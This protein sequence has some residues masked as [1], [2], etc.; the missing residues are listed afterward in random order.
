M[1]NINLCRFLK[2]QRLMYA[3]MIRARGCNG[4]EARLAFGD[5]V[6]GDVPTNPENY[7]FGDKC[8]LVP[9]I[10]PEATD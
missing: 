2:R 3:I 10:C 9:K 5:A 8:E 7:T 4:F 6:P 1:A